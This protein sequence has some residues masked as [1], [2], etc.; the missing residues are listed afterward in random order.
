MNV[1]IGVPAFKI[2]LKDV[3]NVPVDFASALIHTRIRILFN[4]RKRLTHFSFV[5]QDFISPKKKLFEGEY[6]ACIINCAPADFACYGYCSREFE[7]NTLNCP[8]AS[9]CPTGCP[10]KE[11]RKRL[12]S[13]C[14]LK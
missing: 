8:C 1:R 4:V 13:T 9:N 10:C 14:L 7:A 2:V 3:T 5:L 12:I 11:Y 6:T